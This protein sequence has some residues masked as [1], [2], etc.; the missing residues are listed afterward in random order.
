MNLLEA[1]INKTMARMEQSQ[2]YA[3]LDRLATMLAEVTLQVG[4]YYD[5][6]PLMLAARQGKRYVVSCRVDSLITVLGTGYGKEDVRAA[7]NAILD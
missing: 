5:G 1:E 4:A 6:G 3:T 7:I 2:A